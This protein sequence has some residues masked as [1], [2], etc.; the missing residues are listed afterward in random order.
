MRRTRSSLAASP[1]WPCCCPRRPGA[2]PRRRGRAGLAAQQQPADSPAVDARGRELYQTACASCHGPDPSGPSFYPEVPS[3]GR[4]RRG[5]RGQLGAAHRTDALEGQQ[6]PGH[7]ARRA[8]FNERTPDTWSPTSAR[9]SGTPR[10]P[11]STR[12]AGNL[13]QRGREPLRPGV[14]GLPRHERGRGGPRRP[15]HRGV[16]P[17]RAPPGRGRGDQDRP[18]GRCRSA[19]AWPTTSSAPPT[20]NKRSTTSPPYVES[21][22]TTPYN[23][24]GAPHRRQRAGARGVRG[25][26]VIGLG[27]LVVA[28]R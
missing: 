27:L 19:A 1:C 21:L 13:Q 2:P 22:R 12:P 17:E 20:A 14:R 26:W 9:R 8:R 28:S 4:R 7:R 11:T 16:A 23:E 15:E 6:G 10:S 24:G 3:L 25:A 18:Q 5:G